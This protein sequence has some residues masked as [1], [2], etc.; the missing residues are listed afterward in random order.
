MHAKDKLVFVCYMRAMICKEVFAL[1][2]A[3]ALLWVC[4]LVHYIKHM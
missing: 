2:C 4:L 3:I 1:Q